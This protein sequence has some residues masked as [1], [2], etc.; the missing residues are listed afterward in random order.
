MLAPRVCEGMWLAAAHLLHLVYLGQGGRKGHNEIP[1]H[2][3]IVPGKGI[4]IYQTYMMLDTGIRVVCVLSHMTVQ[5]PPASQ[6]QSQQSS[7][8]SSLLSSFPLCCLIPS[9]LVHLPAESPAF[10]II[11]IG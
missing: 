1:R 3:R 4:R 9:F 11:S 6:Q 10:C 5:A 2:I 8:Q 7:Q